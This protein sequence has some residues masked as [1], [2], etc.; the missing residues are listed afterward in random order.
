VAERGGYEKKMLLSKPLIDMDW[1]AK[2]PLFSVLRSEKG[3]KLPALDNAL[4]RYFEQRD[5]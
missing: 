1:K 4:V 5:V 2:R 3:I